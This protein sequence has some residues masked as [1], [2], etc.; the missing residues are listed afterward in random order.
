MKIGISSNPER[1]LKQISTYCPI[2]PK[3][4]AKYGPV[5]ESQA[6]AAE[7]YFHEAYKENKSYKEWFCFDFFDLQ[8]FNCIANDHID[9]P[10]EYWCELFDLTVRTRTAVREADYVR[11]LKLSE[12][13]NEV[14]ENG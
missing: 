1:R 8:E 6:A 4:F 5:S 2:E 3:I 12:K 14:T 13:F 7:R 10:C 9:Q 11:Y